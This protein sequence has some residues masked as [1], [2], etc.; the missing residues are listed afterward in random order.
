MAD[1]Y[2]PT[3]DDMRQCYVDQNTEGEYGYWDG[4]KI[5]A[6]EF[7][8]WLAEHDAQVAAKSLRDAADVLD[9]YDARNLP[10]DDDRWTC[11]LG[12]YREAAWL[13]ARADAM[14]RQ[15]D[16]PAADDEGGQE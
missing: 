13:R 15:A 9:T 11:D 14:T 5:A 1:K 8:A 10:P 7:D 3:T 16:A 6:A 2:T 4:G 12:Y